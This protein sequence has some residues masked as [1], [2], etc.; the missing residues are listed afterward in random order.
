MIKINTPMIFEPIFK[1]SPEC[2]IIVLSQSVYLLTRANS[3]W[4]IEWVTT[5][6][7]HLPWPET[8][9]RDLPTHSKSRHIFRIQWRHRQRLMG[10]KEYQF[11]SWTPKALTLASTIKIL[12]PPDRETALVR[13]LTLPQFL[14]PFQ[15]WMPHSLRDTNLS[16][17][18]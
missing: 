9:Q 14:R 6:L 1:L 10:W 11:A 8:P 17:P 18:C 4:T 2:N 15:T 5:I 12:E 3:H 16:S 13:I 7:Q